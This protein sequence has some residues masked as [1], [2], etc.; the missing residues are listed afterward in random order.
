M[1]KPN[2]DLLGGFQPESEFPDIPVSAAYGIPDAGISMAELQGSGMPL[3]WY[4]AVAMTQGLCETL[5]KWGDQM[6]RMRIQLDSVFINA[7][8]EVN[9][10]GKRSGGPRLTNSIG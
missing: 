1:S 2:G 9:V 5:S 4:E 6:G 8:G 3:E 10:T 7:A